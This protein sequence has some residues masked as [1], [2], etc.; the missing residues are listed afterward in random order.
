MLSYL[1]GS[2]VRTHLFFG[3]CLG[4]FMMVANVT[5]SF[6]ASLENELANMLT[7]HPQ[8]TAAT[9]TTKGAQ[10]AI[11]VQ[12]AANLP[13]VSFN[14]DYGYEWI[15]NP[16]ERANSDGKNDSSLMR[17]VAGISVTQNLFN[18]YATESAIRSASLTKDETEKTED[19]TRQNLLI[20]GISVYLEV[21][22]QARRIEYARENEANIKTQM[23]LEDE[24][25]RRGS[26]IGIDVLNAKSRLQTAKDTRV[27]YE[28]DLA[29]AADQYM[30]VFGHAPDIAAMLDPNPPMDLIPT[31]LDESVRLALKQNPNILKATLTTEIADEAKR[32]VY[33][34]YLPKVD[35]VGSMNFEENK[36]ATIGVRRDYSV[37]V[38]ANWDLF[39]G[40]STEYAMKKATYDHAASKSTFDY[41]AR[42]TVE[43][44]RQAW[45]TLETTQER[46]SL[47]ENDVILK[48]EI[49]LDT[50]KQRENGAEGVDVLN[51]LDREKEV[52]ETKIKYAELFYDH[53]LA[54][55]TVLYT[56]GQLTPDVLSLGS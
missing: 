42:K 35:L 9:K 15:T 7:E 2:P 28:G 1:E 11:D 54:I 52:Y 32:G 8:L 23:E 12:E 53:R 26:G 14:G 16:T 46:L 31:S 5:P 18:G 19:I 3:A 45:H 13:S 17:S 43:A 56:T 25:V 21:L 40:F 22:K 51:V 30:Q 27:G 47:K 50:R 24:R 20:E 37:L 36:N 34:E 10:E 33:A 4:A 6:G 39:S 41:T 38:E 48:E 55:Y 49:F 29:R 44:T